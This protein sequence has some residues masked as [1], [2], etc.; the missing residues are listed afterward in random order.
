MG[1]SDSDDEATLQ[2]KIILLGDGT[3]GKTSIAMRF[4]NDQFGHQY[5]QVLRPLAALKAPRK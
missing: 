1:D 4:T 2:Y 3:V 5:K